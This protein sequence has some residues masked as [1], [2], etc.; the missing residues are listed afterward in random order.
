MDRDIVNPSGKVTARL[1]GAEKMRLRK[2]TRIFWDEYYKIR[3]RYEKD[4]KGKT[5]IAAGKAGEAR[6][7]AQMRGKMNA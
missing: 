1:T 5:R 2:E 7:R 4:D 3:G 6:D